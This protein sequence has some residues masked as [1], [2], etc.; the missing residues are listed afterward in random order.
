MPPAPKSSKPPAKTVGGRFE[1][2]KKLGAGCFGEVWCGRDNT[3]GLQVAVK[4]E[5]EANRSP[6][7]DLEAEILKLLARPIPQEGFCEVL[8]AA[9]EG[10]F[11]CLVMDI[12]G[13]S[14]EDRLQKSKNCRLTLPSTLLIAEQVLRRIEYL[15][16]KGIVH[17]DI[18]PENFMFGV[19]DK[20]HHLYMIDF[21]LSKRYFRDRHAPMRKGLNL[22]GTARYA[23]INAHRGLEQSRRDDLE[24]IGHML[25]YFVRGSLPWSGLDA[26]TQEDKYR[27]IKEKK[28]AYPLEDLCRGHPDAFRVYLKTAR[29]MQFKDRPDYNLLRQL[30]RGAREQHGPAK[31]HDYPWLSS[32]DMRGLAPLSSWE[33]FR[34]PDDPTQVVRRW[35]FCPCG[36]I[37]PFSFLQRGE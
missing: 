6:Q 28:Q 27:K 36:G 2:E 31:D 5:D 13:A 29:E 35:S 11:R 26:K 4:F 15:H 12:L 30:F 1:I 8:Y 20:V 9:K 14:L 25:I 37:G 24:A 22:T 34:Q 16:S 19:G 17:R 10:R 3:T 32:Q 23:S 33:P 7:L 21:G 18:K